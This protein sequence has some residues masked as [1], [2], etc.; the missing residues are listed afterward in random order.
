MVLLSDKLEDFASENQLFVVQRLIKS[1]LEWS[2]QDKLALQK[3]VAESPDVWLL[4]KAT[5]NTTV[6]SI[7]QCINDRCC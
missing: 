6:A 5:V 2:E 7:F 1:A 3:L 4:T